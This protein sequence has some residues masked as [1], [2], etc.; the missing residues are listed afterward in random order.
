MKFKYNSGLPA[1]IPALNMSVRPGQV[2]VKTDPK[3]IKII[4]STGIFTE[5]KKE[6]KIVVKEN[7]EEEKHDNPIGI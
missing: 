4:R 7:Q 3:K 1:H 2:L 5:M 6:Q